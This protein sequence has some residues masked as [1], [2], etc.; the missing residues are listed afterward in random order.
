MMARCSGDLL[1]DKTIFG[2]ESIAI[3]PKLQATIRNTNK[4]HLS[5][6]QLL[7]Q[8]KQIRKA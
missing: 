1:D 8:R 2:S 4:K 3:T 7:Q 5:L 6:R